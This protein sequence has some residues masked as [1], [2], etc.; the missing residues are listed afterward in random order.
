MRIHAFLAVGGY[1]ATFS[2]NED[3]ELDFRLRAKGFRIWLEPKAAVRYYPRSTTRAL[4]RQYVKFG[5]GRARTV[6]KHRVRLKLRHALPLLVAPAVVAGLLALPAA[7]L[8]PWA[9]LMAVPLVGWIAVCQA[10]GCLFALRDRSFCVLATGLALMIMHLAWSV[11]FWSQ[12]VSP[13]QIDR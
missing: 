9:A 7:L 12:I 8:V 11:G 3:A 6:R 4:W 5:E 13:I 1:D 2:H 10:A